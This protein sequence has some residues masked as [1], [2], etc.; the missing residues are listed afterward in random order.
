MHIFNLFS[1]LLT[2]YSPKFS[3]NPQPL[4]APSGPDSLIQTSE[5]RIRDPFIVADSRSQTYYMYA[6]MRNRL[7]GEDAPQG[8]EVYTS[9]DLENWT[10][11]Q[12]VL[13]L[14]EDFWARRS[15]WAPEVHFYKGAYYLFVTLTSEQKLGES[16]NPKNGATL[17]KRGTH[18][19]KAESPLGPF[20]AFQAQAHTPANWMSLDGTLWIESGKPYMAFCH[21]W[22]QTFDGTM[23]VVELAED[24]SKP[25]G[26]PKL[27]FR[28]SEAKWV[29]NMKDLGFENNGLVT[30]GTFFYKNRKGEL[31]MIWSSFGEQKYAIGQAISHSGSI[32]GPWEQQEK[33]LI[34]AN[35]GH[36]MLFH[37]F[38]QQMV[39]A[40]HQPNIR[41]QE[42]LHLAQIRENDAGLLECS[43]DSPFLIGSKEPPKGFDLLFNGQNLEGWYMTTRDTSYSGKAEDIFAVQDGVI[44]VYPT[45]EHLSTQT[46]AGL[47]TKASY[48][49]FHLHMEYRWGEKKFKPRHEFVRDAG[50]IF[51]VYGE[52]T[53]WPDGVECQIQEGDTGDIWAIGTRV[54][55]KVSKVIRNYA[56][57]G[58]LL[59]LGKPEQRFHRFHRG[60]FWEVPGWNQLDIVVRG[61]HAL[62]KVNGKVVNE[63][64]D[65]QFYDEV[66]QTYKPLTEGKILIQAE[67][68]ELYY[69]NIFIKELAQGEE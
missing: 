45:Q 4:I 47:T 56:P 2:L 15:V 53:V 62:F 1:I 17:W 40:Y 18:I 23:E 52:D 43:D 21:E 3:A 29:R 57:K 24:L 50:V 58:E 35:G 20:I 7:S 61:D 38:D 60:Y 5:I 34:K 46:F 27:L 22:A 33:L 42:R 6:Q 9:T 66:T 63:A 41:G 69:R 30:D 54:S 59:T 10:P 37:T 36:G 49:H 25:I 11:P 44:H 55:S 32:M 12:P 51:H 48:S 65:M 16:P 39:L 26:S 14:A 64:I 8:V 28:A 67:G 31:I 68:A 19:F 13:T